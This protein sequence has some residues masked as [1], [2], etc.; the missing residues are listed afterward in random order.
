MAKTQHPPFRDWQAR[1]VLAWGLLF[2]STLLGYGP[3][4]LLTASLSRSAMSEIPAV[5]ERSAFQDSHVYRI[6]SSQAQS[7]R[8]SIVIGV[9]ITALGG[10]GTFLAA[11][12]LAI[13]LLSWRPWGLANGLLLLAAMSA[14]TWIG[15]VHYGGRAYG[16]G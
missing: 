6:E 11:G 8:T 10:A 5:P 13:R 7:L 3:A 12:A 2:L 4:K 9:W 16:A 1:V 14:L 15:V